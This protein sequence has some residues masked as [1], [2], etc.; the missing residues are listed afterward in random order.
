MSSR[1]NNEDQ[2][3]AQPSADEIAAVLGTYLKENGAS[4]DEAGSHGSGEITK[5][6]ETGSERD[7]RRQQRLQEMRR[8]KKQQERLRRL[9]VPCAVVLVLCVIFAGIG[10]RSLVRRQSDRKS[11][12]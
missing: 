10:I 1:Y 6:K 8:R 9:V 11:V 2:Y 7:L 4:D 3:I 5:T 12:V